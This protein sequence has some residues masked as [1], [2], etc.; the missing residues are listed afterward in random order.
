MISLIAQ[1]RYQY[2]PNKIHVDGAKTDFIKS[3][4]VQFNETTNY[5]N[6]M[7]QA[8]REKIDDEYRMYVIPI[9]FNEFG[10]ELL[11]RFQHVVSKKWFSV[12][13][14]E[15]KE[16]VTQMR[17]ANSKQW[18]PRQ[19]RNIQQHIRCLIQK[20][21]PRIIR[22]RKKKM[23]FNII[24]FDTYLSSEWRPNKTCVIHTGKVLIPRVSLE[25]GELIPGF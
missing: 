2:K 11:D 10:K 8:T 18:Q 12:S 13:N 21:R 19:S 1:L 17:M 5:E 6:I 15:H 25:T 3:L 4:K 14:T 7:E 16:L 9:Y 24:S 20:V 23:K 22:G